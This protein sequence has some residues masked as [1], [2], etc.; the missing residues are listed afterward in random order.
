MCV[1]ETN[2]NSHKLFFYLYVNNI[3]YFNQFIKISYRP[4]H[5]EFKFKLHGEKK[6]K[7]EIFETLVHLLSPRSGAISEIQEN[8]LSKS[9]HIKT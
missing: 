9:R 1:K 2:I 5:K 7:N 4:F 6:E 3:C 8:I